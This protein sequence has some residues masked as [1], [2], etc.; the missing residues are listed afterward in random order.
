MGIDARVIPEAEGL[1]TMSMPLIQRNDLIQM[2][3]S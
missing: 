1:G 2:L 3:P